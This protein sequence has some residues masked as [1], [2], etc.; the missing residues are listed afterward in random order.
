MEFP[1]LPARI[2]V[3][4]VVTKSSMRVNAVCEA[5]RFKKLVLT[6]TDFR[7]GAADPNT[8]N[9]VNGSLPED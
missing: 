2:G 4:A 9:F 6:V 3:I 8:W 7:P 1:H 5:E